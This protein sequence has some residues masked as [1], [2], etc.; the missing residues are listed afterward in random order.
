[1]NEFG[2]PALHRRRRRRFRPLRRLLLLLVIVGLVYGAYSCSR[3]VYSTAFPK[4]RLEQAVLADEP[5]FAG[6]AVV[7]R[8][9]V[10]VAAERAGMLNQLHLHADNISA[11]EV[12]FEIV[13]VNRLAAID[14]QLADEA[15]R[16]AASQAQSSEVIAHLR[17][18]VAAA[19]TA[20]R[21]LTVRYASY[22]RAND[23]V[24]ALR[25][26]SDLEVANRKAQASKEEYIFA[27][28]SQEQYAAR[29]EELQNQRRQ[30]IHSVTSPLSGVLNFAL[31]G[32]EDELRTAD[33]HSLPLATFRQIKRNP[34]ARQ[35]MDIIQAG[36]VVGSIV[37][38]RRAVLLFEAGAVALGGEV[39]VVYGESVLTA[40]VL[41]AAVQD[42]AS[43]GLVAL[44]LINPP[45]S[46][47]TARVVNISVRPQGE[48]LTK[49]PLRA[50]VARDNRDIVY[51][52]S[53][54]GELEQRVVHV[55][56][57]RAGLAIVSGLNAEESVVS[58]PQ[59]V[60]AE[61]SR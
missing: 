48:V 36:Q 38:S 22:L 31:D 58:N 45:A 55:R 10:V 34:R 15:E 17:S 25:V 51:V 41:S 61:A 54:G 46:L 57:R 39:E 32:W 16:M 60:R 2:R 26:F 7:L 30:A 19:Q 18:Q 50:V 3:L 40:R 11:G 12:M 37:D 35:N 14:R 6:Q 21:D 47:L 43:S 28:R 9:E 42:G 13:D 23:S 24:R 29:R 44:S 8:D 53:D 1:M 27:A 49:I 5:L 59:A 20:V 52:Q 56:Q 33:Y 4:L